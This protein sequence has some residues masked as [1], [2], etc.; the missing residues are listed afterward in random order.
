MF[1]NE[2]EF[3]YLYE[4]WLSFSKH[5]LW[6]R[7]LSFCLLLLLILEL[8]PICR[9]IDITERGEYNR[10]REKITDKFITT[11]KNI[12]AFYIILEQI[13]LKMINFK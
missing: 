5:S 9:P 12:V 1:S 10:Y 11:K 8:Y 2:G 4:N 6:R 7:L 13:K 3:F